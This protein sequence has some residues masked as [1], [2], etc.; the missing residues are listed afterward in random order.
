MRRHSAHI[1]SIAMVARQ[2]AKLRTEVVFTGGAIVG[3]L[4]TD[5]AA[6]EVRPTDDVDVIVGIATYAGYASLQEELRKL[7][8]THDMDGPN[9]RFI[10]NG[11]KVDVM[12]SDGKVLGFTNRWY[13]FAMR[14]A[15]N[16]PLSDGISIRVISAPAFIATKLEAFHDRGQG[17]FLISHDIEDIIAVVDGR[18]ELLNEI[19]ASDVTLREY[20]RDNFAAFVSDRVFVDAIGMNLLPDEGS[21]ARARIIIKR[22]AEISEL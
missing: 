15:I 8:F 1:E 17:D 19:K 5:S 2:L 13:E 21:Q 3:L 11:L 4:L 9:C 6:P 14:S 7:D 18:P 12:P 20:V 10:L 22:M 16:H